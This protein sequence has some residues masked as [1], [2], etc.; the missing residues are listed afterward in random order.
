[1]AKD[2]QDAEMA[3]TPMGEW[4][5]DIAAQYREIATS[6]PWKPRRVALEAEAA[7]YDQIAARITP[8][9]G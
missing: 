4:A 2:T 3:A 5:R 1:M 8:A 6:E 9:K 7:K